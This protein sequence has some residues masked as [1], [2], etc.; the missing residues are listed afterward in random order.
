MGVIKHLA[1]L[2]HT[3][4]NEY[5]SV[6]QTIK[7]LLD[8]Q[9]R[10]DIRILTIGL[11][12]LP[13]EALKEFFKFYL[14]RDYFNREKIKVSI[15]GKWYDL[16]SATIEE[17]KKTIDETRDYDKYFLNFTINYDGQ[18]EIVDA[19]RLLCRQVSAGKLNI[20]K[21]SKMRIKENLYSSY[22]MPPELVISTGKDFRLNG[23][24]LW[25]SVDSHIKFTGRD[26]SEFSETE[27]S[28][29]LKEFQ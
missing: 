9:I 10:N 5:D 12:V 20:D 13:D 15:I 28:A 18:E 16:S 19:C 24:L 2:V 11:P 8:V 29:I 17:L 14:K 6:F 22:F 27:L 25:D 1:I 21:I 3:E 23:F 7:S 26:F 4:K